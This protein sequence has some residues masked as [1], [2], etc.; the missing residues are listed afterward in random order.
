MKAALGFI[1]AGLIAPCALSQ[2]EHHGHMMS[3]APKDSVVWRMP[4]MDMSMPMLPGLETALPPTSPHLPLQD[5]TIPVATPGL[6]L[7]L[8]DQDT[9]YLSATTVRRTIAGQ[10]VVMFGYNGQYPGPLLKVSEGSTVTVV[11]ENA[12]DEATTVHW[13]GLRL[14]NRFDGIPGITQPPVTAGEDFVYQLRFPDSGLFWYHPHIRE[15][16]QQDLGL[17]GNLL[18]TAEALDYYSPVNQEEVLLLDDILMDESGLIPYGKEAPTH[19][20]MGRFG[21]VMLTNGVTDYQFDVDQ[22]GVVRFHLTNVANA[23]SFNVSFQGLPIKV[24]A[25]DVSR[26]EKEA[27]VR[28]VAIAP[29]ERYVIEV[30]FPE[31]GPVAI[32]NTI[33]AI[34][35]FRG[36]FYTSV[37]TLA[38]ALVG[39][40]PPPN[41]YRSSFEVLRSYE[42]VTADI[43]SFRRHF[44]QPP[45]KSLTL[46]LHVKNLPLPIMLSMEIDTLYIP[47]VEWNDAM[48]MMNWLSTGTQVEWVLRDMETGLENMAIQWNFRVGDVVKVRIFNDP[49]SFHPMHHPIHFHGQRFLVLEMDGVP[50]QHLVWKDTATVPVGS[51]VDFLVDMSNPGNWMAHCHIAEHLQSGMMLGFSVRERDSAR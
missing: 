7:E 27:W 23:R 37:D 20:L 46:S 49:R 3:R 32:T 9:L 36:E 47:P 31:P 24:V 50:N 1:F 21:N 35:H 2:H 43:D 26:F 17:Y 19:A 22:G 29:S 51:T 18:V 6:V 28:S 14:E 44:D 11:F 10:E 25:S 30:L 4:P 42:E 12:L 33:Q 39:G 40:L 5:E 16:V 38:L 48:P 13:H 15:D 41:D 8:A 45:D 34:D